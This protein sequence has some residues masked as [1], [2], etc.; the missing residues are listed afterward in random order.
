MTRPLCPRGVAIVLGGILLASIAASSLA[1]PPKVIETVPADGAHDVDP[2]LTEI[3]ITFD[4]D[5]GGQTAIIGFRAAVRSPGGGQGR[6][7]SPRVLAVPVKL[8]PD[9]FYELSLNC[10]AVTDFRNV[11]GEP[12][13]PYPFG[14]ATGSGQGAATRPADAAAN[15]AAVKELRRAIDED[16]SYRDLRKLN[17]DEL[18]AKHRP[19]M[20]AARSP[21]MFA[22]EAAR[23]LA[24][25]RD[26]H[27]WLKVGDE[28][29]RT[30][31]PEL[32][33]NYDLKTLARV[34]PGWRQRSP[35]V[36]TGRFDDRTGY[37]LITHWLRLE[38]NPQKAAIDALREFQD[39]EALIVDV[40]PNI[41]GNGPVA[42]EFAAR[43]ID[44][45]VVYGK[46]VRRDKNS[47]GGF[48]P[49]REFHLAPA[50]EGP[51]YRG[52]VAVLMGPVC[53]STCE[54]F[55]EMMQQVP[56]CKLIGEKSYGS[57]GDPQPHD[58][59]NGVVVNLPSVKDL[60]LDGT[61]FEGEG[62]APDIQV[63]YVRGDGASDP[64]LN[65]AREFLRQP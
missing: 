65:A 5:M 13:A 51:K 27:I 12:L 6:W 54:D 28:S 3:R 32:A 9:H 61:C 26:V 49:A 38:G 7:V 33:L 44:Q 2:R 39:T 41:G 22:G 17:W 16:Y 64:V 8:E 15:A 53:V 21:R 50:K 1:V 14:F 30:F 18:F 48:A 25:A 55:L 57:S 35:C 43:F 20:E 4:Q 40:R 31:R 23:L 60:R 52:K 56:G 36:Y 63:R 45:P 37:I 34:V 62:I 29:V 11:A 47:P 24:S 19:A 59:G 58:L 42:A 10:P 46:C